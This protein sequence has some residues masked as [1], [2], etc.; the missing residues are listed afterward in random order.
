MRVSN[1]CLLSLALAAAT[2][3][4]TAADTNAVQITPAFLNALA[5]EARTNN[6]ALRAA[7]ARV[8]AARANER[9]VRTW[10]DPML[11]LGLMGAERSMRRDDGDLLYGVE[12]KLPLWGKPQAE[13][14]VAQ[15]ETAVEQA[16]V[17][18]RFQQLRRDLA[19][20][21]FAA[22][23]ADRTVE[24]SRQDF[25]WLDLMLQATEQRYQTGDATQFDVL[26]LQNERAQRS[27]RL[28]TELQS[29]NHA[30]VNLNRLLGRNLNS[31]WPAL[32]LPPVAGPVHFNERLVQFA[33]RYEPELNMRRQE[34]KQAEAN[35][36]VTRRARYPDV[37]LGAETR[38]YTG[39]GEFRQSMVTLSLNLPWGN[40]KRY[41]AAIQREEAKLKSTQL[42]TADLELALRNEVHNLTVKIDA[43][44]REALLYRDEILPRSRTALASV[45]A[46]WEA[47]RGSFRD[48]LDARRML[49]EAEL[50][51]AR[52]VA[53]QY[54]MLSELILCCGLG[55]L[56]ALEMIDAQPEK[57]AEKE[58]HEK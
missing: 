12:Q 51:S 11:R 33:L 53:E 14:R 49:V 26:R 31:P 20:A 58:S 13:R 45:Q 27:N 38:D 3:T 30:Q 50:M 6:P 19:K 54:Q 8:D 32:K 16:S 55:D 15:A 4:A 34:I 35:V 28:Q 37:S 56:E 44:R 39:T 1:L 24:V 21:V 46:V 25:T 2:A 47:G 48:L 57:P 17:T 22:A 5:D 40:R 52:A 23:L 41:A 36:N 18:N 29:L 7:D 42:D 43:A 9:S 10:E